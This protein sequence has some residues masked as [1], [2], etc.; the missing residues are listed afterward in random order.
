MSYTPRTR[1]V[2]P[3][4]L[5][6]TPLPNLIQAPHKIAYQQPRELFLCTG[7]STPDTGEHQLLKS[8][9]K[10]YPVTTI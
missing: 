8:P 7:T 5:Y 2:P 6:L 9:Q 10:Q 1:P 4:P 3:L